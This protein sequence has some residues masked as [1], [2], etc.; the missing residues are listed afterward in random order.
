MGNSLLIF[1]R[2]TERANHETGV[3]FHIKYYTYNKLNFTVYI[4]DSGNA[5]KLYIS[6]SLHYYFNGGNHNANDFT[7]VNILEVIKDLKQKFNIN[8][9]ECKI[10]SLE[11]GIN[12]IPSTYR[13]R[14]I[15]QNTFY[16]QRKKFLEP[17]NKPYKQAGNTRQNDFLI[18]IYDKAFQFPEFVTGE[19]LR[20]EVKYCRMR[21]LRKI[22]VEYLSDLTIRDNHVKLYKILL[23]RFSEILMYDFT[24]RHKELTPVKQKNCSN[25]SNSN[26]W[27]NIIF[28]IKEGRL[29]NKNFNYH[30]KRLKN[31]IRLHSNNIL[32][33]LSKTIANKGLELLN[34]HPFELVK[35]QNIT[36]E[37]L[38]ISTEKCTPYTHLYIGGIKPVS[39][40]LLIENSNQKTERICLVTALDI[41]M[42]NE[43]QLLTTVGL[44]YYEKNN[45]ELFQKLVNVFLTGR[46]N[47]FEQT[48]YSKLAKQ[49]R[50]RYYNNRAVYNINQ[51]NLFEQ[52]LNF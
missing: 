22:G 8:P 21:E 18:K 2:E 41:S 47:K 7:Y 25:Y 28:N 43:G 12:I 9:Y 3:L 6:G 40:S 31:I 15:L 34:L 11:F 17:I 35:L 5:F 14:L 23:L 20:F 13:T 46:S 10:R 48:T 51:T 42:Q 44:K 49:I 1:D 37:K 45:P 4:N 29:N 36:L 30:K 26:Y 16:H 27:E 19:V 39:Y 24:I 38:P 52:R 32:L 33:Q 50:N